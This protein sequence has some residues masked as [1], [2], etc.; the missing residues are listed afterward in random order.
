M[1]EEVLFLGCFFKKSRQI[2]CN[3]AISSIRA[4]F[5]N[6]RHSTMYKLIEDVCDALNKDKM[7]ENL[8]GHFICSPSSLKRTKNLGQIT[9]KVNSF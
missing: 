7:D 3:F 4:K 1:E 9:L 5:S 8:D 2:R 6:F